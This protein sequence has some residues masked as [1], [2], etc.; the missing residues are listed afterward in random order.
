MFCWDEK[1]IDWMFKNWLWSLA[2]IAV[3][4][5]TVFLVSCTF[6]NWRAQFHRLIERFLKEAVF[7]DLI[8][9]DLKAFITFLLDLKIYDRLIDKDKLMLFDILPCYICLNTIKFSNFN[10]TAMILPKPSEFLTYLPHVAIL[11]FYI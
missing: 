9:N 7:L 4:I 1:I 8:Q 10:F 2:K 3:I 6:S 5:G 11:L